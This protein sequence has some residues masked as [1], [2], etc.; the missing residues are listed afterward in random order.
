MRLMQFQHQNFQTIGFKKITSLILYMNVSAKT[1][2]YYPE[3]PWI[4]IGHDKLGLS[5][6][7]FD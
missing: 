7:G 2:K 3:K 4:K 5:Q 1:L 6:K